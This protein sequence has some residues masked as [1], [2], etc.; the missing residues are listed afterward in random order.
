M[1]FG[2]SMS[3]AGVWHLGRLKSEGKLFDKSV[4]LDLG[5]SIGIGRSAVNSVV[6]EKCGE[7]E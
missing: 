4:G 5:L 1:V 3:I 6:E 7:C 2:G